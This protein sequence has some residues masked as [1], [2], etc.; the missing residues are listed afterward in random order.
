[1][2]R[3]RAKAA[4][5]K[6]DCQRVSAEVSSLGWQ[7][8]RE[9]WLAQPNIQS[10]YPAQV[11]SS[12]Y[13]LFALIKKRTDAPRKMHKYAVLPRLLLDQMRSG[14][15][16]GELYRRLDATTSDE[17]GLQTQGISGGLHLAF[18][19]QWPG[20]LSLMLVGETV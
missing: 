9:A 5:S 15:F 17:H 6:S 11:S 18:V 8:S 3:F 12:D 1:M 13:D 16:E 2:G 20:R 14:I 19:R 7:K 4:G 10:L